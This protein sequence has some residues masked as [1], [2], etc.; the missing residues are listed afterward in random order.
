TFLSVA[1]RTFG[2]YY[3]DLL[4]A[5]ESPPR[6]D[7]QR[8]ASNNY[9]GKR[10]SRSVAPRIAKPALAQ[11]DFG[12]DEPDSSRAG[13]RRV[14]RSH[15]R[16]HVA[17]SSRSTFSPTYTTSKN[18]G[19]MHRRDLHF[20]QEYN[21]TPQSTSKDWLYSTRTRSANINSDLL[22]G[23]VEKDRLSR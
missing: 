1:S 10:R 9:H 8:A 15:G 17:T 21:N 13:Q 18:T 16:D 14:K 11:L 2:G 23:E 20:G 5:F 19:E 12:S 7:S 4:S 22:R 3:N 6:R